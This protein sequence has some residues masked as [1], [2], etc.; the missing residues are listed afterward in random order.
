MTDTGTALLNDLYCALDEKYNAAREDVHVSDIAICPR[1]TVFRRL[2]PQKAD[3]TSLGFFTSGE[4]IGAAI[5]ALATANPDKYIAEYETSFEG[6]SAHID[7][8]MLPDE[9]CEGIPIE[10]KS[11]NGADMDQPKPH[12]TTQLRSYMAMTNS[13][14]GII[15][16]QLLQHFRSKQGQ[17]GKPF[18]TWV[19]TMTDEQLLAERVRLIQDAAQFKIALLMKDPSKARHVAYDKELNWKCNYCKFV[20]ECIEMRKLEKK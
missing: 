3:S 4:A 12:Y 19:I 10:C 11:Y 14:T 9:G 2:T 7:L 13:H 15:L 5:Q 20:N 8:Y 17:S 1:E 16:V 18:K 6:I